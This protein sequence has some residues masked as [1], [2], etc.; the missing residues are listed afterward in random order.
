M[1]K[2]FKLLLVCVGV[3][4]LLFLSLGVMVERKFNPPDLVK[5]IESKYNCRAEIGKS[6]LSLFGG[7]L[8]VFNIKILPRDKQADDGVALS[9]REPIE[10]GVIEIEKVNM[11]VSL[12]D[13]LSGKL[14][15]NEIRFKNPICKLVKEEDGNSFSELFQAPEIVQGK[16]NPNFAYQKKRENVFYVSTENESGRGFGVFAKDL[17]LP[18]KI[19]LFEVESGL[20]FYDD[21]KKG[22]RTVFDN[23]SLQLK[24]LSIDAD[25][26]AEENHCFVDFKTRLKSEKISSGSQVFDIEIEGTGGELIPFSLLNGEL[27]PL[28]EIDIKI[29]KDG[30]IQGHPLFKGI[31]SVL[32]LT[33]D[34]GFHAGKTDVSG[35]LQEDSETRLRYEN[36]VIGLQKELVLSL[37]VIGVELREGGWIDPKTESHYFK[38]ALKLSKART[39]DSISELAKFIGDKVPKEIYE[40]IFEK[41]TSKLLDSQERLQIVFESQ[42]HFDDPKI[43]IEPLY[44]LQNMAQEFLSDPGLI[45]DLLKELLSK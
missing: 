18:T 39:Q 42:S 28:I 16:Q 7:K 35:K 36:Q 22:S 19:D 1:N 33:Q 38:G 24:K 6:D 5:Q 10:N 25:N 21:L 3:V 11:S 30:K 45:E 23:L 15:F 14:R 34:F 17:L 13:I 26:L 9:A 27:N 44:E 43:K 20:I 40:E 31:G 41:I 37:G 12:L 8:D 32:D 29:L 4:L 2:L